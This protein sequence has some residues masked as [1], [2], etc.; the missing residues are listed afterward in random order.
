MFETGGAR[1]KNLLEERRNLGFFDIYKKGQGR[2][3]R[4]VTFVAGIV[5]GTGG[6]IVL[7]NKLEA[8][9]PP[10]VQYGVPSL[11]VAL[12]GVLVFWLV[13]RPKSAD[14]LIATEGEMKKVSW[15]SRKE[16]V[17]STK[18]VIVAT[19]LMAALL[20]TVDAGFAVLSQVIGLMG[21]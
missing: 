16:I 9:A 4:V 10:V 15:S 11:L 14:F 19:F 2:Y 5:L 18:V 21:K 13:N 12:L 17:G 1:E 6:A 7:S 3:A 20:A 8:Y